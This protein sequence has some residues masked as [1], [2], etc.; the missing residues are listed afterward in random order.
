MG[1]YID[2][3]LH[4]IGYSAFWLF[5]SEL[6]LFFTKNTFLFEAVKFISLLGFVLVG[7]IVCK[8]LIR[9]VISCIKSKK[10]K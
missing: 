8:I 2:D 10:D 4:V 6:A 7:V 9:G 3:A 5:A 1:D